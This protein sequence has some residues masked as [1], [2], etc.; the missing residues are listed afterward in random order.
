MTVYKLRTMNNDVLL[1]IV[2]FYAIYGELHYLL[3]ISRMLVKTQF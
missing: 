1:R 2:V 3:L